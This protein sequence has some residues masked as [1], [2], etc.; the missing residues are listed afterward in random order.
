MPKKIISD[1]FPSK[2]SIRQIPLS[3]EKIGEYKDLKREVISLEENKRDN[4]RHHR[5]NR[6]PNWQRKTMNPKLIIWLIAIICLLALFFGISIIFSSATVIIT[7]KTEKITF[8]NEPYTA[9]LNSQST[10]TLSFEILK[11][12]QDGGKVIPATEEKEVSQKATGKIVIY[13]NYSISPQRLITQT[14]FEAG[15]GKIYKINGP[16]IVPGFKKSGDK[17]IPGSVEATVFADQPGVDYNLKLTDLTGDFTIPAFKGQLQYKGFYA[18][19]STDITGGFIGKQ[20]VVNAEL[21]KTTEDSI[22]TGLRVKLLK[23]LYAVKP[24]NY[25]IFKD[26]Y[27][28]DYTNLA[29]TNVDNN[30]V[31]INIEGNLSG[32]VFNNLKLTKYLANK[33]IDS[34]DGLPAELIPTDNLAVTLTGADSTGLW[35]NDTLQIKFNGDAVVKW[36]Y[37]GDLIKRQLAGRSQADLQVLTSPF[38]DSVAGIK[39]QFRPVWTKYFPDNL[40]KIKI[41]EE[42]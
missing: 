15:N 16:V 8:N 30:E 24:D 42:N 21:R 20:R 12:K 19:A 37:D 22:K 28:V 11:V 3:K 1:I 33:K 41:S 5:V 29:D 13:N 31:K 23:E 18:R 36:L 9:K 7:P 6:T 2:K 25:I 35:K 27:S 26:A 32:I 38:K 40:S 39:V 17:I 4:S 34:F 14:R 10:T